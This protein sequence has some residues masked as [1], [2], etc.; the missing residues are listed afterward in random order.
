MHKQGKIIAQ[1]INHQGN[2]NEGEGESEECKAEPGWC[3][4][5]GKEV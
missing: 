3:D 4:V 2:M 5:N 1:T